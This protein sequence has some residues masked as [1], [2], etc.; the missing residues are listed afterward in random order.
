MQV[1]WGLMS[2]MLDQATAEKVQ[3]L[4]H[5]AMDAYFRQYFSEAQVDFM[6]D[7]LRMKAGLGSYPPSYKTLKQPFD[8]PDAPVRRGL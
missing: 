5:G 4:R 7:V 1:A 8:N 3:T 6:R 2:A